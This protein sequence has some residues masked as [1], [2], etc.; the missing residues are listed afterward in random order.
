MLSLIALP[1]LAAGFSRR[2][3]VAMTTGSRHHPDDPPVLGAVL[4]GGEG[5]RFGRPKAGATLAGVPMVRRAVDILRSVA[6]EVVVSSSV[7]VPDVDVPVVPDRIPGVGPLAGLEAALREASTRG[8]EAVLVLA[9]DLPLVEPALLKRLVARSIG[10]SAVAPTRAGG[11]VEPLC[12]VYRTEVLKAVAR[13]LGGPDRSL[14]GLFRDVGGL[15]IP[16]DELEADPGMLMN[17]NTP[18]DGRHAAAVLEA[19]SHP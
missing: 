11:G 9:C 6:S 17:V 13:R 15:A 8:F 1:T 3:L 19:R 5:R 7:P 2:E 10:Q 16:W 14:H 18:A 12:A 4:A